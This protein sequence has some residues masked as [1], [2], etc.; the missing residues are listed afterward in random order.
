MSL[1]GSFSASK[2]LCK[3]GECW[4]ECVCLSVGVMMQ[5]TGNLSEVLFPLHAG[6]DLTHWDSMMA[7]I[8]GVARCMM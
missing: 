6:I 4:G 5:L 7:Y 3:S 1:F 8:S 2:V